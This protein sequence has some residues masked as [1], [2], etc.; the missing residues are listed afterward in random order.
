MI[1]ISRVESERKRKR[2]S[3]ENIETAK[4]KEDSKDATSK[5]DG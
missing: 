4:G 3:D 2:Q 5:Y 1:V